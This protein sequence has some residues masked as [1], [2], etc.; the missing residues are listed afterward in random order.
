[1]SGEPAGAAPSLAGLLRGR[2]AV[3]VAL[4]AVTAASWLYMQVLTD[5]MLAMPGMAAPAMPGMPGM[6]MAGA[7]QP[8]TLAQA[9]LTLLMWSVMMVGMML[10]SA[11]PMILT[12]AAVNARRRARGDAFVPTAAFTSGYLIVWAGFSVAA[13]AAQ[14]GL[15]AAALLA[16]MT[17]QASPIVGGVLFVAAGLFQLTPLKYACLSRC[18]SPLDF[19]VNHWRDGTAGALKMGMSHGL[20]CLG[21]CW[22]LMA[23]MFAGGAMNLLWMA[24]L[25]AFV[26]A[27]KLFP[28]GR[29]IA[30]GSG[31]LMVGYGAYL[32][33]AA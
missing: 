16:P 22:A 31:V 2:R 20:H 4:A 1:M 19:I 7:V 33:A 13:T 8:W 27:E 23:L 6:V 30:R 3:V 24:A 32:L 15:V 28:A 5:R 14:F 9:A 21:C 10:P 26:F 11:S 18:R 12:F 29:W 17:A 25:A